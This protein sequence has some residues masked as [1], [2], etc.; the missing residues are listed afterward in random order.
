MSTAGE[1]A[2]FIAICGGHICRIIRRGDVVD[3]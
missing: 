3:W 2:R 1:K